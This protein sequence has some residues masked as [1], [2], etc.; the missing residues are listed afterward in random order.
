MLRDLSF[1]ISVQTG[2]I[3]SGV[4]GS[5]KSALC[6]ALT[7]QLDLCDADECK[8]DLSTLGRTSLVSPEAAKKLIDEEIKNDDSDFCEGGY[9]RGTSLA[10]YLVDYCEHSSLVKHFGLQDLLDR[11]LRFLSTGE[12][13]KTILLKALMGRPRLLILDGVLDGL[14]IASRGALAE[15]LAN[16]A[17]FSK[18]TTIIWASADLI[19]LPQHLQNMLVLSAQA[20]KEPHW[21][22]SLEEFKATSLGFEREQGNRRPLVL[23]IDKEAPSAS[24]EPEVLVEMNKLHVQWDEHVV[25]DQFDW[26]LRAGEHTLVHGPNGSGKSTLLGLINGDCQQVYANKV[27]IFGIRRGSG[28]SV[29]E[30]RR[31]MGIVS[32]RLHDEFLRLG[33]ISL[34]DVI[35]SGFFDSIGL[36]AKA[37]ASQLEQLY[38]WLSFLGMQGDSFRGFATLSYGQQRALLLIRAVVKLPKLLLL[39]EPCQGLDSGSRQEV[40]RVIEEIARRNLSTIV[41]VSHDPA[42]YLKCIKKVIELRLT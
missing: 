30:L 35:L 4:N 31:Q 17:Q 36:Y 1:K 27:Y 23:L 28:E 6:A 15:V 40:L 12:L 19:W 41:Q 16:L 34:S 9:W 3:I 33:S 22:G 25:F 24:P 2:L 39:D 42:E 26:T 5:G 18:T 13:R 7:G 37:G 29:W 38:N 8:L 21:F 20:S 11:G 32:P 14:D 10:Q